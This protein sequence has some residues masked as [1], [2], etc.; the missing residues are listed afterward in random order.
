MKII[1]P[2]I[3][4]ALTLSS[5]QESLAQS[6][7]PVRETSNENGW[8]LVWQDEFNGTELNTE[9]WALCKR[10]GADWS[11]TMSADPSLLTVK[12]GIL[13]LR[14]VQNKNRKVDPSPYLTAGV[15]SKGKFSFLHGKII[16][17]ARFKS[18]QGAWPALWLLGE[19]GKHPDNG[20]ID[21]MEHLN[22]DPFVYHTVH[23]P[24]TKDYRNAADKSV[25]KNVPQQSAKTKIN[26]DGWNVYGCEWT[27]DKI[28]FL[29]NGKPVHSY[30]RVP[31]LGEK[32]WPF[33]QPFYVI[34]SMQI[35]GGW[36][37]AKHRGPTKASDFPAGME[38][39]WVR[40]YQ[41]DK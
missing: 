13:H 10:S 22:F 18:A 15:T 39:D 5:P 35:G 27:E 28:T 26:K 16:I 36:V 32:Q 31:S 24:L 8:K 7:S 4:A 9:N 14:G 21:L 19:K 29:V 2:V 40:H 17:R 11:N 1:F 38:I 25:F 12:D 20:E 3:L 41:K 23:S 34:M 37:N 30:P 33:N 6:K